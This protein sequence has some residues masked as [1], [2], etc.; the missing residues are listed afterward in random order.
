MSQTFAL[1]TTRL[2]RL[3]PVLAMAALTLTTACA[4]SPPPS[5]SQRELAAFPP[6]Q[7]GMQ[8]HVVH[9]PAQ[10]TASHVELVVGQ[11]R[12]VD[13]NQHRLGGQLTEQ[14]VPGWG[15]TFYR[16]QAGPAVSTMM[17]CPGQSPSTQWV[18]GP[19]QLLRANPRLPLVV[20]VPTG[21]EV[22]YR[23]LTPGSYQNAPVQP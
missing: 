17:A 22:R 21:Y 2:R 7:A 19:S 6:A 12:Q 5:D 9:L 15:Y 13:C 20:Y 11:T 4:S 3:N 23:L 8:R 1:S 18:A 16:Y 14:D 10:T